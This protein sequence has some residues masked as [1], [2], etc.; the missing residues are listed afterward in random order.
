MN[1][2][3]AS[4][5]QRLALLQRLAAEQE[6][7]AARQLA[8]ALAR[9]ANAEDR[10]SEL[11]HYEMEYMART[12]GDSGRASSVAALAQHAG[13][14]A[15]LREAVQ[16]QNERAQQLS[17]EVEQ[18]RARWVALHRELEKL[19]QLSAA[20]QQEIRRVESRRESR[21]LDELATRGWVL[22]QAVG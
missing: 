8:D 17:V 18:A 2:Q 11:V 7:R 6:D 1:A 10:R 21:E 4:P 3:N 13:F 14:V 19:E 20:A 9:H 22:R 15:K 16:F 5:L 12:P